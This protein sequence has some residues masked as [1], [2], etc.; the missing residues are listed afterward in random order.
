[1]INTS[2]TIRFLLDGT[3]DLLVPV[4]SE[5]VQSIVDRCPTLKVW[6]LGRAQADGSGV[7]PSGSTCSG[8]EIFDTFGS[9]KTGLPVALKSVTLE[10]KEMDLSSLRIFT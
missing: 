8:I 3:F 9:C 5:Q 7:D 4:I 6:L 2:Q 1:M 10:N